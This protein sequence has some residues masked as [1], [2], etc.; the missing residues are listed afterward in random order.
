MT[1]SAGI[2]INKFLAKIASDMN[3]PDGQTFIGP[4]RVEAFM[5][6]LPVEKF[7]GV[8]KVTAAKM[9]SLGLL[10]GADLKK[11]EEAELVRHF[12][13]VGHFYYQIARGSTSGRCSR[14][15]RSSR[16]RRRIRFLLI[17]LL[18]RK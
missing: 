9:R 13:K 2:S 3:K 5:E 14:I 15:G 11:K 10:T 18:W 8:G 7:F 12:G 1:A 4:S 6:A 16:W 17:L